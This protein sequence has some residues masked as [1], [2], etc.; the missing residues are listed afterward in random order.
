MIAAI[1]Y[2][3]ELP[4]FTDVPE[5]TVALGAYR[6]MCLSALQSDV[7]QDRLDYSPE[8]LDRLE[9]W[10]F[11]AKEP[12]MLP[13]GLPVASAIGFY[14][15]ETLCKNCGFRWTVEPFAFG[16]DRYEIGVTR[17]LMTIMLT[18]G[19][20]PQAKGNKRMQSLRRTLKQYAS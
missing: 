20:R 10:F 3:K 4:T 18:F 15:G 14:L 8:S 9:R 2:G 7:A 13:S 12:S 19:I 17:P 1:S 5:A 16:Q 11:E 6:D